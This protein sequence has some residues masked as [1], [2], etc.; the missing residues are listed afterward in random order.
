[1]SAHRTLGFLTGAFLFIVG[2]ALLFTVVGT[3][4]GVVLMGEGLGLVVLSG[5]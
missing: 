2:F 3:L 1:M 4:F 5:L